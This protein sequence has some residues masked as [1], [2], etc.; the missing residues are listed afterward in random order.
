MLIAGYLSSNAQKYKNEEAI[1]C[2]EV[3]IDGKECRKSLT[4]GKLNIYTNKIANMLID[5]GIMKGDKIAIV[6]S[7]CIEWIPIY[8]SLLKVG[9]IAVP[10]NYNNSV[11]EICFCISF[12]ECKGVFLK[13]HDDKKG[14]ILCHLGKNIYRFFI[15]EKIPFP[16]KD[17]D[18]MI[19][20]YSENV[21]DVQITNSDT[22]AIYFSSGTTGKSKAI[23]L[24]HGA[25]TSAAEIE[26]SHHK[27]QRKDKFLCLSPLYHTGAKIHWFG[28]LLVGGSIVISNKVSP[29]KIAEITEREN[30]SIIWLVVP[31]LQDILEALNMND[32]SI[33][34]FKTV[35]LF[36]SGASSI[37]AELIKRWR[38]TFPQVAYDISYGLTEAAGPGC[39][40]LGIE[41]RGREDAIGKVDER[42]IAK[43]VDENGNEV[44][45]NVIGEI[46]LKGPGLMTGYYKDKQATEKTM[47][48]GWLYTG[49]MA[50]RDHEGFIFIVDRKKDVVIS[51]GENIYPIQIESYLR[52]NKLIKD[53][54]VIGIPHPRLGESLAAII[55]LK[56]GVQLTKREIYCFCKGLPAYQR[57]LRILFAPVLRNSIGKVDKKRLGELYRKKLLS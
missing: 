16:E 53:V 2:V 15:G 28:S 29:K 1:V 44:A 34:Q 26:L 8:F 30:I 49:D 31:Q 14:E 39:I 42:W 54:A 24:S 11:E 38:K 40:N 51:G 46:I 21:P 43:I 32:I 18:A 3:Q 6:L 45:V 35:R 27:Q 17:L 13:Y 9:I 36:H 5:K 20:G 56:E 22:A 10:I 23:L 37:P 4:W 48:D 25:I 19:K 47:I 55:E 7:N 33:E 12:A 50:Y 52:K 57:P 41:T